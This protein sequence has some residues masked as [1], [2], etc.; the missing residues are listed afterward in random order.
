M[1]KGYKA[2]KKG[3]INQ[4]G[5]QHEVG[6]TYKTDSVQYE[7]SGFYFC[8]D[9]EDTLRFYDGFKEPIDIAIVEGSGETREFFDEYN[10][11]TSIAATEL[12]VLSIMTREEIISYALKLNEMRLKKFLAGF[13]L[14]EEEMVLFERKGPFY[15]QLIDYFQR[16]KKDTFETHTKKR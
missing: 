3:L 14:T 9:L 4:F 8:P 2:Y 12:H 16:G 15:K 11:T 6:H 10:E 1:I 13:P 7:K 5:E